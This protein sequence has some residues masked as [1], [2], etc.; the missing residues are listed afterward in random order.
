M[1]FVGD[2][3]ATPHRVTYEFRTRITEPQ[4]QLKPGQ[5]KQLDPIGTAL[6]IH[7]AAVSLVHLHSISLVKFHENCL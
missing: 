5:T 4:R 2:A 6:H 7:Q 3:A 1:Y